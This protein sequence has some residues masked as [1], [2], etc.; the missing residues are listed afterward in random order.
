M[1]RT[2]VFTLNRNELKADRSIGLFSSH[3]ESCDCVS[4][5]PYYTS[6]MGLFES[7][8]HPHTVDR[9]FGICGFRCTMSSVELE[10][11]LG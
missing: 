6:F 11:G 7:S 8:S 9:L 3:Q 2:G 4:K 5:Y 1:V 10:M